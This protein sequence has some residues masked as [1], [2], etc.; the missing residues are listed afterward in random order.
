MKNVEKLP[1]TAVTT[2]IA[3]SSNMTSTTFPTPVSG[4][5]IDEETVRTCTV[6]KK[7]ESPKPWMSPPLIPLSQFHTKNAP[8]R[9]TTRVRP[10]TMINRARSRLWRS[11]QVERR[12]S[13]SPTTSVEFVPSVGRPATQVG[14][15]DPDVRLCSGMTP[16][17]RDLAD[18]YSARCGVAR[19]RKPGAGL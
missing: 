19:S 6:A 8:T 5:L 10:K 3:H 7:S 2:P 9:S 4:F 11:C 17:Q 13:S 14:G 16:D 15:S 12:R 18:A 1:A